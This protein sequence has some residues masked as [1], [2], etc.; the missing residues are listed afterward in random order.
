ME[1]SMIQNFAAG[2][3]GL[4]PSSSSLHKAWQSLQCETMGAVNP[5]TFRL[6]GKKEGLTS[7]L[8]TSELF[9]G[10]VFSE[11]PTLWSKKENSFSWFALTYFLNHIPLQ[12]NVDACIFLVS[13]QMHWT[14]AQVFVAFC[15]DSV[16]IRGR[17]LVGCG[18]SRLVKGRQGLPW[19]FSEALAAKKL[20]LSQL[21]SSAFGKVMLQTADVFIHKHTQVDTHKP[22]LSTFLS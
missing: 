19:L 12:I 7:V 20:R 18:G 22:L 1:H 21:Q 17:D 15:V 2:N 10:S 11:Y 8:G 13:P 4:W 14:A 3:H 16:T 6:L 5:H 9:W